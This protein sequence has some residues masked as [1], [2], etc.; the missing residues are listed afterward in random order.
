[1]ATRSSALAWRIPG[2][3]EPGGL[4]SMGSHRVR[5]EWSDLAA[6][7]AA[8]E[9][10]DISH[11]FYHARMAIC[12]SGTGPSPKTE[13]CWHYDL[14]LTASRTLRN[15]ILSFLSHLWCSVIA[16]QIK[17]TILDIYHILGNFGDESVFQ[18][19]FI[20]RFHFPEISP[21]VVLKSL[22]WPFKIA[23]PCLL[24][25][26]LLPYIIRRDKLQPGIITMAVFFFFKCSTSFTFQL[27]PELCH[28]LGLLHIFKVRFSVFS[29]CVCVCEWDITNNV[30]DQTTPPLSQAECEC[31]NEISVKST[32]FS[33]TVCFS[34][35]T[36]C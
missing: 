5:H 16:A 18:T 13:P 1:M 23:S 17:T 8:K 27:S 26:F 29:M 4:P 21:S 14:L 30:L 9:T 6:A 3:G 7:A 2:T 10:T 19:E 12:K 34:N 28:F 33:S 25:E 20:L 15:K 35:I 31:S 32:H 36:V 22:F 11:P 24:I